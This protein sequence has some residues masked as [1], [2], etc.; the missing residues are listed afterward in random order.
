MH[1]VFIFDVPNDSSLNIA[2][3]VINVKVAHVILSDFKPF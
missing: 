3:T 1:L 2:N